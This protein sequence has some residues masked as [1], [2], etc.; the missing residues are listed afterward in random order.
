MKKIILALLLALSS[1]STHAQLVAVSTEVSS[2][3]LAM[4]SVGFEL[5]TANK[6][7]F[8]L[9]V[10][11]SV[12]TYWT[13]KLQGFLLHPE[14][15]YWFSGRPIHKFFIGGAIV[16][17]LYN[18][19]WDGKVYDGFALG[20]GITYGYVFNIKS[21]APWLKD[22]LNIEL[23]SGFGAIYYHRK[24][25]FEHDNFDTDFAVDG[26]QRANA[27]GYYLMPTRIGVS[28]VY[29]IK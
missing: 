20:G 12:G 8:A 2:D 16:G 18:M 24:E 1:L 14:Y 4:P 23:H 27:S 6:Q 19:T 21:K 7:S 26:L 29:I 25:Y 10:M 13:K 17:G 11:G 22:R 9:N 5:V 3:L 28:V 15:R